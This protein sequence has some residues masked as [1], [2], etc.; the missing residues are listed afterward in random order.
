[1]SNLVLKNCATIDNKIVNII[2][3]NGIIKDIKKTILP[4]EKETD[5]ICHMKENIII[6]GLIDT[7]GRF[8]DS[9]QSHKKKQYTDHGHK[10]QQ[11]GNTTTQACKILS[12]NKI[13]T[14]SFKKTTPQNERLEFLY[15]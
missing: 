12:C 1:M 7:H 3:E 2:I 6:P 4:S 9:R 13:H 11:M 14:K 5:T 10:Q 15:N 8:R